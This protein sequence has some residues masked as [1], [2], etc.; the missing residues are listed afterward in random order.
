MNFLEKKPP[1]SP[2]FLFFIF[3][4]PLGKICT[5]FLKTVMSL[6]FND[7]SQAVRGKMKNPMYIRKEWIKCNIFCLI[8]TKCKLYNN[9]SLVGI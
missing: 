4:L 8:L 3:V 7:H 6:Y 5:I 1:N 9:V 2:Q